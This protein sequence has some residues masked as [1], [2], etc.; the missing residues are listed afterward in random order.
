MNR[1]KFIKGLAIAP[2]AAALPTVAARET[3][4][5]ID[6]GAG[7]D[8]FVIASGE[9]NAHREF[10]IQEICRWFQVPRHMIGALPVAHRRAG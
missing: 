2:V 8:I 7:D 5:G 10:Q 4:I 1:R 9:Y 3:F 6:V